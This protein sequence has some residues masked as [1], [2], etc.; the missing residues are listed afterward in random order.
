MLYEGKNRGI[1]KKEV[2]KKEKKRSESKTLESDG[3]KK[4]KQ[5]QAK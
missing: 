1:G 5:N 4:K 2:I 3:M